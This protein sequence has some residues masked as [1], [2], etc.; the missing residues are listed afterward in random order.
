MTN[1]KTDYKQLY[2]DELY[3]N[4][5]NK[6]KIIELEETIKILKTTNKKTDIKLMILKELKRYKSKGEIN[7][8]SNI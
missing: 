8:K 6:Q 1:Q 3:K 4:K 5:K 2:Y 7:E